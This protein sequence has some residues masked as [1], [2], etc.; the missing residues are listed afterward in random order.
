VK[1]D[2]ERPVGK[3]YGTT[4]IGPRGQV[5]IP[6][7]ARRELGMEAGTKLL[8]FRHPGGK[9]L[10]L[11]KIE[12]VEDLLNVMTQRVDEFSRLLRETEKVPDKNESD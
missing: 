4:I 8:T 2:K 6:V 5:V 10:L 12:A 1:S 9:G 7:E 3:C 11:I